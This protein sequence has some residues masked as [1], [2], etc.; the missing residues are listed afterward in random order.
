M[1]YT[2]PPGNKNQATGNPVSDEGESS[3]PS[4]IGARQSGKPSGIIG[5]A[6]DIDE[7][8]NYDS[9][10]GRYTRRAITHEI[11]EK[12]EDNGEIRL[13]NTKRPRRHSGRRR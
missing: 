12:H 10:G 9:D 4:G 11:K 2:T 3:Q 7:D 13:P 1:D 5:T 8:V 6:E